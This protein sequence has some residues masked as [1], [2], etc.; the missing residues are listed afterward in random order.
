MVGVDSGVAVPH[1]ATLSAWDAALEPLAAKAALLEVPMPHER[2]GVLREPAA[3]L[4][5]RLLTR[6]ARGRGAL[7]LAVG[8]RL[9]ALAEG[10]RAMQLGY[11][12]LGDYARER[13]GMAARTALAAAR[14][15]RELR[16]RPLLRDAVRRGE[17][18]ARKAEVVLPV[19]RGGGEAAWVTRARTETVRALQAAVRA[20][21]KPSAPEQQDAESWQWIFASVAPPARAA[22]DEAMALAGKVL[23]AAAPKWERLEALC[24]EFLGAHPDPADAARAPIDEVLHGPVRLHLEDL[25]R[26]FIEA[27]TR[28]AFLDAVEP[29]AAPSAPAEGD[30]ALALDT[31]LRRLCEARDRWD[32]V[33]GRLA[34]LVRILGLWR[35]MRFASFAH[36]CVERLGMSPRTVEQRIALER[37]LAA[38]PPLGQAM[39]ERRVSYE[40]AR[41]IARC[42]DE[43]TVAAWIA[44]AEEETCVGLRR[45]IESDG[46][47][48]MCA[49]GALDLRVPERVAVL[50]GMAYRAAR[51]AAGRWLT[52]SECL[53]AIARHFV[54]TWKEALKERNTVR[55]RVLD[56][57]R[58]RCQVPGCS[59][60]AVQ[61]HH[62]L[63]RSRGG[64]DEPPNLLSMCAP[65]HLHGIHRGYLRVSGRAPDALRWETCLGVPLRPL[66]AP[67]G[68]R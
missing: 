25:A 63:F 26:G 54:A 44:R 49:R 40:K 31:E 45:A 41:L 33:L 42:A 36:Y 8:E 66:A 14:L 48:Q 9:A 55:R 53:E 65:H 64:G 7:D 19:A 15:A 35:D 16:S 17:V 47:A 62:V 37:R 67:A 57:D 23:G 61:T 34:M 3:L 12:G 1:D 43:R 13:L 46:E 58:D 4:L 68:G 32:E 5:D 2:T 6:V 10:D 60:A 50:V 51:H 28:W 24:Q 29:V 22:L 27:E 20:V 52:P 18:T 39:R 11:S 30:G 59:R 21:G 38:L 56:R